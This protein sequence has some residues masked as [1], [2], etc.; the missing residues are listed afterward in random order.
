MP[1]Q[2]DPAEFRGR[3]VLVTGGSK[4]TGWATVQR[5]LAAGA[6]VMTAAR[7][8]PDDAA[9]AHW[10]A[11]DLTTRDGTR[12]LADAVTSRL[13]GVDVLVHVLGGSAA[14]GGGFAALSEDDWYAELELNLMAAVRLDRALLPDMVKRGSGVVIHV[15]SIQR[16]LPLHDS[17]TAYAAAKAA[18]TTY[19]KALSKEVGPKG[20]RVNVVSPGWIYTEASDALMKRIAASSG[21]T[22]ETARQDVLAAL[23]GIPLGRPA[24]PEDV[25]ELIAFLASDRASAIHGAEYVIDGGTIPT[26]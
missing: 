26:V 20:V 18:L 1:Q 6:E 24:K 10:L 7:R 23:G 2:P 13:G 25:A 9:N 21:G 4:G 5:F 15:S 3:R 14:P 22:V 8:L 19:S 11:A 12:A 16:R 17:T